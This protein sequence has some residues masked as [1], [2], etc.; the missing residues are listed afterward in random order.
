M[1]TTRGGRWLE[2]ARAKI[3]KTRA[4]LGMQAPRHTHGCGPAARECPVHPHGRAAC[5]TVH[6]E[7]R[8]LSMHACA[9]CASAREEE[10]ARACRPRERALLVFLLGARELHGRASPVPRDRACCAVA[11]SVSVAP[12]LTGSV[13]LLTYYY[14]YPTAAVIWGKHNLGKISRS[15]VS[16]LITPIPSFHLSISPSHHLDQGRGRS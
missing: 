15:G 10:A 3:E 16:P 7:L 5:A 14:K 8:P 9:D 2:K 6:F 11:H 1:K 12:E 13:L 4:R